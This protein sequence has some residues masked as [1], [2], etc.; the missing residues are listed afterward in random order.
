MFHSSVSSIS[1]SFL[2]LFLLLLPNQNGSSTGALSADLINSTCRQCTERSTVLSYNF[3]STSLQAIPISHFTNQ[4]GLA[5]IAMELATQNA[6][7]T[8]SR[9]EEMLSSGAFDAFDIECLKDCLDLY[10]NAVAMLVNSIGAFISEEYSAATLLVRTA[11]EATEACEQGFAAKKEREATPLTEENYNLLELSDIALC[12]L[13]LLSFH[14][15]S[16]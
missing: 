3:C 9:I 15:P 2:F 10:V 11:M 6:T 13:N 5:I 7:N 8:V 4:Q 16:L 12:I 14:L 1:F